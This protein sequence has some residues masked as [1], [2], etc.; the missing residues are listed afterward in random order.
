MATGGPMVVGDDVVL[1]V[2]FEI[3][4]ESHTPRKPAVDV[5]VQRAEQVHA[6]RRDLPKKL[7]WGGRWV[8]KES[9]RAELVCAIVAPPV[10]ERED[11][12]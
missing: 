8:G 12:P 4:V 11:G 6:L 9:R 2:L 1:D 5:G 7:G 3:C 10:P